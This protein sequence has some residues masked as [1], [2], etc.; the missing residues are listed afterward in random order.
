MARS[1]ASV[2]PGRDLTHSSRDTLNLSWL[3]RVRW[4]AALGQAVTVVVAGHL[5]D[6]H[7]PEAPVWLLIALE[8]ASNLVLAA[9]LRAGR[10]AREGQIAG[11]LGGDILILTGLLYLTGGPFNPFSFVYLVYIS[12][13][14]VLL[15]SRYAWM[16]AGL[17]LGCSALLFL[18][19]LPLEMPVL[20]HE[21]H[22]RWHLWG[23]WVAFAVAA[24]Y[25]IYSQV[26]V[27][28]ALADREAELADARERAGRQERLAALATLAGGAAHELASPL[29]TVAVIACELERELVQREVAPELVED[30]RLI[31]AELDHC[32]EILD[33][34]SDQ[35]GEGT[36]DAVSAPLADLLDRSLSGL[37]ADPPVRLDMTSDSDR[38]VWSHRVLARAVRA[39]VRN[40]QDAS[41]PGVAVAV[42]ARV[43]AGA[44]RVE[45]ADEGAGMTPDVLARAG[46][47]FFTT[48]QPGQ[49]MG[50]GL[51]LCRA[52]AEQLGGG[53]ELSSRPGRGTIARLV[54]PIASPAAAA[55][56]ATGS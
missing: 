33:Q 5:L 16:L 53:V 15:R 7:F 6:V 27:L 34:M 17:S 40:A 52:I 32:R 20:S 55:Q 38:L 39:L 28:Q 31:R 35:A 19:H 30:V 56:E 41:P 51:F 43:V 10:A 50:L 9:R 26:R 25:I 1:A 3:V 48:K 42:Q 54:V 22:M 46:E 4:G 18:A 13:A 49:G 11:I 36:G 44:L 12:L 8:L 29:S 24:V 23:M 21:D 14:V 37:P 45:V 47:P 2:R